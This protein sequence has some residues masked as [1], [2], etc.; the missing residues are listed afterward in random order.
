METPQHNGRALL[1]H[2]A[3]IVKDTL[4]LLTINAFWIASSFII[5]RIL[6]SKTFGDFQFVLSVVM[7]LAICSLPGTKTAA[8]QSIARGFDASLAECVRARVR[9]AL[10]GSV[11]LFAG[12]AVFFWR[13][14][15]ELAASLL[16]LT[17]LFPLYFPLNSY[18]Y[19]L[20]AKGRFREQAIYQNVTTLA[21]G[22]GMVLVAVCRPGLF[23]LLLAC[24]GIPSL[25]NLFYYL[26]VRRDVRP[27]G[28]RDADLLRY[29][30]KLTLNAGIPLIAGQL[31]RLLMYGMLGSEALAVYA[32]AIMIPEQFIALGD[33]VSTVALP[34]LSKRADQPVFAAL[35]RHLRLPSALAVAATLAGA[36]LIPWALHAIFGGKYDSAVGPAQLA[37]LGL[38]TALPQKIHQT[39]LESRKAVSELH[40]LQ[41]AAAVV[42]VV[43]FVALVPW[44]QIWG[45]VGALLAMRL[46]FL[47][48]GWWLARSLERTPAD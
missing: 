27:G 37:F 44:L 41:I 24:L 21:A 42:K 11:L 23:L 33:N 35:Q 6:P 16:L 14:Q 46:T 40:R 29:S 15:G 32:V 1:D 3:R 47:A 19:Y 48:Y 13:G 18:C 36:A 45:A 4:W 12:A 8:T 5:A 28:P 38:A 20:S 22:A 39:Y 30:W 7:V 2:G 34:R 10:A 17:L 9:H 43:A 25:C 31:D 26:R